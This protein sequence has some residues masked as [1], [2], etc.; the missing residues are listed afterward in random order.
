MG[1]FINNGGIK[2]KDKIPVLIIFIVIAAL[3]ITGIIGIFGLI[4]TP[5]K[6]TERVVSKN[7]DTLP[8]RNIKPDEENIEDIE[9]LSDSIETQKSNTDEEKD[10]NTLT[11]NEVLNIDKI[12]EFV[13][14]SL[15]NKADKNTITDNILQNL[16]SYAK[17]KDLIFA[18][19]S[20]DINNDGVNEIFLVLDDD[21]S[22]EYYNFVM[23]E[24]KGDSLV[25]AATT[26]T[27]K[28]KY[29]YI[30]V[31]DLITGGFCEVVLKDGTDEYPEYIIYEYK[32]NQFNAL[33]LNLP[34]AQFFDVSDDSL[35]IGRRVDM[36]V[37]S[38]KTFKWDG[39]K[40]ALIN[41]E[42]ID[43]RQRYKTIDYE[44]VTDY[45]KELPEIV[46]GEVVVSDVYELVSLIGPNRTI[47]LKPGVY[48]LGYLKDLIEGT[49]VSWQVKDKNNKF[50]GL[51]IRYVSNLTIEGLG[52]EPVE[53]VSL[54]T[55]ARVLS[56]SD[57]N[58]ITLKNVML[59]HGVLEDS[60]LVE[61]LH[62]TNCSNISIEK[63]VIYG[64]IYGFTANKMSNVS[65]RDTIIEECQNGG[66]VFNESDTVSMD[67]CIFRNIKG[68][69]VIRGRAN[70]NIK[71]NRTTFENNFTTYLYLGNRET[72]EKEEMEFINCT[73]NKNSFTAPDR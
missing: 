38:F 51:N 59:G 45:D 1:L 15:K 53:I 66:M 69:A 9:N 25:K 12:N 43:K 27:E 64:S 24:W 52:D 10:N 30:A 5:N 28:I 72:Y 54:D 7:V 23:L 34:T 50:A 36:Q 62:F 48:D 46:N 65:M 70:K 11:G 8:A 58:N 39:T 19:E 31:A 40:F 3:I 41:N 17:S 29:E 55:S 56:F 6:D 21:R 2:L 16:S 22:D 35:I 4:K 44:P 47:K 61:V 32:N 18:Q 42:V 67:N 57:C 20:G 14:E 63:S 60:S 68:T 73:F 13:K 26:N 37:Y 49:Y 33:D 71:V